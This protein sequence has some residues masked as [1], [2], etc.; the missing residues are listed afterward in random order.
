V[1]NTDTSQNPSSDVL[2]AVQRDH[3]AIEEMLQQVD[4]ARGENRQ[5]TF[6]VLV[7]KLAVHETAEEEVVHPLAKRVGAQTVAEDVLHEEDQAKKALSKLDG[8]D[9]STPE[10]DAAFQK[11]KSDVLA[12]AQ[13]EER[14][15]HPKIATSTPRDELERLGKLFDVAE[16]TAPTHPHAAAPE[17]RAGNLMLGPILAV[18]DR[19]KDAIRGARDDG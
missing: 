1:T 11:L 8:M 7:R 10:F 6:E 15:E 9:V 19:I 16:R 18:T 4:I 3:R 14:D 17:S 12:H 2:T 13:H 5:R